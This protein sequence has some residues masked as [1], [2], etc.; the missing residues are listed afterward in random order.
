MP[1]DLDR[2]SAR[3][4]RSLLDVVVSLP[5]PSFVSVGLLIGFTSDFVMLTFD[6]A[7]VSGKI[8]YEFFAAAAVVLLLVF[9]CPSVF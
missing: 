6:G 1:W 2:D 3:G 4:F 5:P 8:V 9:M 7:F